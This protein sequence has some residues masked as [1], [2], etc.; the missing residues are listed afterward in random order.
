MYKL[1]AGMGQRLMEGKAVIAPGEKMLATTAV[2]HSCVWIDLH[3]QDLANI[4]WLTP[5]CDLSLLVGL[6]GV[7]SRKEAACITK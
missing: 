2:W 7:R 3:G 5:K 4:S 1:V 6:R